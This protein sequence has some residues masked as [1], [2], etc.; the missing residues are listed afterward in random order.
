MGKKPRKCLIVCEQE[1]IY[2]RAELTEILKIQRASSKDQ[3]V[4]TSGDIPSTITPMASAI[5]KSELMKFIKLFCLSR[6]ELQ[7][8]LCISMQCP[9]SE[10]ILITLKDIFINANNLSKSKPSACCIVWKLFSRLDS[11]IFHIRD[12]RQL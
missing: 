3:A 11:S 7:R 8:S 2:I 10:Y 1:V 6:Q 5:V 4:L 12:Y 9:M